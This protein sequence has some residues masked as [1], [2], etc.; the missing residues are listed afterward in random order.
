MQKGMTL[1]LLPWIYGVEGQYLVG[2]SE[3]IYVTDDGCQSF[4][5]KPPAE[6]VTRG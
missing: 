4:F 3:T 2:M 6:L 5:T 1:H